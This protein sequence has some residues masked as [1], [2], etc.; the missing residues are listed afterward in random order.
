MSTVMVFTGAASKGLP[1]AKITT[2]VKNARWAMHDITRPGGMS[3]AHVVGP[4]F[5]TS[6]PACSLG[7]R[8]K[9]RKCRSERPFTPLNGNACLP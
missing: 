2:G 7:A 1:P 4:P 8:G 5:S 3:F 6:S 9:G